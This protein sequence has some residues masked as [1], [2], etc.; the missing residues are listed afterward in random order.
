[1]ETASF[2]VGALTDIA[3]DAAIYANPDNPELSVVIADDKD[4]A[5]GGIGVFDMQGKLLQFRQ[6][7]KIGNVDLRTGFP[8]GGADIVLVGANNRTYDTIQFWSFDAATRR[9]GEPIGETATGNAPNYGFC[10]YHSAA[11]GQFHAFVTQQ[12]GESVVE[13]YQ[14]SES[15][16]Q[17]AA[18][19]VRSFAMGSIT[20]GCVADDQL[21]RLYVAQEDVGLWRY[22]AEPTDGDE[23]VAVAEVGDGHVV[24]DLEG[25]GLALGP[26]TSG[27]LV[28]SIQSESRFV[29]YDRETNAYLGGFEVG[30]SGG[31]DAVGQTDG[32]DISTSNLG[33]GFPHGALVVHDGDN[34]NGTTSN[35]KFVPLEP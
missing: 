10:L 33:A 5:A 8:F 12:T 32:L 15:G 7:G 31:I 29:T 23:R 11:T 13:Q 19:L 18:T 27:Y 22:G 20:E 35:L 21:G 26:G 16:G 1:M 9:L 34:E 3:D 30:S 4:D 28:V 6:E 24:A 25:V 2:D 17:L 14:L